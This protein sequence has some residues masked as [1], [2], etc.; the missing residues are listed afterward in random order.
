MKTFLRICK[1]HNSTLLEMYLYGFNK[2]TKKCA[3]ECFKMTF[4]NA[5]S[6]LK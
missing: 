1:I 6:V 5:W 3:R 2:P 4:D